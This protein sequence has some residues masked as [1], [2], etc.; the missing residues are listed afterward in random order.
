MEKT[1][2][3]IKKEKKETVISTGATTMVYEKPDSL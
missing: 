3:T 1:T 2:P